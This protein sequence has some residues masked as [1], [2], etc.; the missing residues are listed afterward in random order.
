MILDKK[1]IHLKKKAMHELSLK[2]TWEKNNKLILKTVY[3]N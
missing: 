1:D 3:E 2:N